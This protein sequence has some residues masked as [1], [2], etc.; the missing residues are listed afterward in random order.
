MIKFTPPTHQG[1]QPVQGNWQAVVE[2]VLQGLQTRNRPGGEMLG[3]IDTPE[4]ML[5]SAEF[6]KVKESA[7]KLQNDTDVVVVVGIGGSYLG[8]RAIDELL[9][10]DSGPELMFLGQTM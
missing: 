7:A 3:W 9:A 2:S 5:G 8:A 4:R 10:T 1:Y 6:K